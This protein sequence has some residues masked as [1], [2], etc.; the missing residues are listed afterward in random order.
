MRRNAFALLL[1]G[2]ISAWQGC[3]VDLA[4]T[5]PPAQKPVRDVAREERGEVV[6]VRDT[7]IDL[8]TGR[9]APLRTSTPPIGIGPFGV[10]IPIN[11]GG[12]KKVE[13]PAEEITVRLKSGTTIAVVQEL[14]SPPFAPG[15]QVKV[16]FE[17]VDDPGTSARMQVVR[18]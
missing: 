11:I 4:Q 6:T 14:S 17:K 15:E 18:D 10:P 5:A 9:G 1:A 12:E 3:S 16:L 2:L 8:R 13:A 7:K